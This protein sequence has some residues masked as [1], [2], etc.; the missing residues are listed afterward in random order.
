[1]ELIVG[2]LVMKVWHYILQLLGICRQPTISEQQEET[3]HIALL[4]EDE[5]IEIFGTVGIIVDWLPFNRIIQTADFGDSWCRM[6]KIKK[7]IIAEIVILLP[8]ERNGSIRQIWFL[9][10]TNKTPAD[11]D[12]PINKIDIEQAKGACL[13]KLWLPDKD[14]FVCFV[15]W[16]SAQ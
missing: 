4:S 11:F 12:C 14:T 6:G 16:L 1:M 2:G 3:K 10:P 13:F 8:L 7:H 15:E 9:V 5:A